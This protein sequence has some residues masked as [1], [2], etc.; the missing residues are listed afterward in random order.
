MDFE[1][2]HR[3]PRRRVLKDGKIVTKD[4]RSVIDCCI[5]DL[6]ETGARLACGNPLGVPD[7]FRL[8]FLSNLTIRDADVIWRGNEQVGVHFTGPARP[9]PPRRW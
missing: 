8:L 4:H 7:H 6:S 1:D 9:A 5:R 3:F 2:K